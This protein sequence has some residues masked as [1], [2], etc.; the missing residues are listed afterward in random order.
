MALDPEDL[1]V[2][3]VV[4]REKSF[5]RA[6]RSLL[7]SQPTVSER[8]ARM[9]RTIG[10]DVFVRGPRGVSLTPSGERLR[11]VA[12]RIVGLM[13]EAVETARSSDQ[14]PPLQV[15]VHSTFAYRAVPLVVR[16]ARTADPEPPSPRRSL[17][18][19]HRH[20]ARQGARRRVRSPWRTATRTA[21]RR[22]SSGPSRV[23]VRFYA[24]VGFGEIR[25]AALGGAARRSAQSLGGRSP[26]IRRPV[27]ISG[28]ERA[29]GGVLRCE[30]RGATCWRTGLRCVRGSI[31]RR[32]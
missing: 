2:F 29:S 23:R 12:E 7:V 25:T 8:I 31:G 27:E 14:P 28:G 3:L 11:P 22:P 24:R 30:H 20:V 4:V 32:G 10:A 26:R 13:V 19:D 15:G 9:E 21:L 18:P 5:G 1:A 6:A 17:R 16:R